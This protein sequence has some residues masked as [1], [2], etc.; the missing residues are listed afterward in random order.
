M[1]QVTQSNGKVKRP[2]PMSLQAVGM[3]VSAGGS[4]RR[5]TV[6]RSSFPCWEWQVFNVAGDFLAAVAP[7][8]LPQAI[9]TYGLDQRPGINR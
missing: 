5:G 9:T 6:L 7:G 1:V 8:A 4:I 3:A 2:R